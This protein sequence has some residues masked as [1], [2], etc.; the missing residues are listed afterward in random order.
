LSFIFLLLGVSYDAVSRRRV[1]P[2]YI[3][4]GVLLVVSVPARLMISGTAAWREIALF[5]TQ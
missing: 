5:L 1:H 3:W 4:G 2:V